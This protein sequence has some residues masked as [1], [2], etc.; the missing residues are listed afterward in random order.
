MAAVSI[1]QGS[2]T[3][4][5]NT[6]HDRHS[7]VGKHHGKGPFLV[8]GLQPFHRSQGGFYTESLAQLPSEPIQDILFIIDKQYLFP[9]LFPHLFPQ[10]I[11]CIEY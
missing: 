1:F 4:K 3:P 11:V 10:T 8:H 7:E 2:V 9:H 6:I 5:F